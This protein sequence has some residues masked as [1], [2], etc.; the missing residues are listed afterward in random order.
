MANLS[1]AKKSIRQDKKRHLSNV[2]IKS[3]LKTLT[4]KLEKLISDKKGDEAAKMLSLVMSKLDKAAKKGLIKSHN[5]DRK[6]SRLSIKVK[7]IK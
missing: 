7:K 2:R 4:K 1:A 3:E 5:A 6:K